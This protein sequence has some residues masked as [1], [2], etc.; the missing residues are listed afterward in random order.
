MTAPFTEVAPTSTLPL[1]HVSWAPQ[2]RDLL[3]RFSA[4]APHMT[5]VGT[6]LTDE[7]VFTEQQLAYF[8]DHVAE[9]GFYPYEAFSSW[10]LDPETITD[11]GL[12]AELRHL[13]EAIFDYDVPEPGAV[14]LTGIASDDGLRADRML[15]FVGWL[16][17]VMLELTGDA[18][19]SMACPTTE[20]GNDIDRESG[21]K[22]DGR[23]PLHADMWIPGVLFNVFYHVT[24]GHGLTTLL[25]VDDLWPALHDFGMDPQTIAELQQI[26]DEAGSCDSYVAFASRLYDDP[27]WGLTL[28]DF[29]DARAHT[30]P[31]GSGEGY[32]VDD[33]RWLHGRTALPGDLVPAELRPHRMYRLAYNTRRLNDT[34]SERN[35]RWAQQGYAA[36]ACK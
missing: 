13:A 23:L 32:L 17:A 34:L 25:S 26:V 19:G 11:A 21:K 3:A 18:M 15:A 20:S 6:K 5:Q 14:I 1:P 7:S 36:I 16:R 10:H 29:L 9:H 24:P 28:A 22:T 2:W 31:L 4:A 30:A 35:L 8:A 27:E 12:R 33:R